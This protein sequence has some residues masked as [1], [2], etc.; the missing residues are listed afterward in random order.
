MAISMDRADS[1]ARYEKE[2]L[3]NDCIE[4]AMLCERYSDELYIASWDDAIFWM[5]K[6]IEIREN[7]YG[8]NSIKNIAQY[9]R[10]AWIYADKPSL[11]T[12]LKWYK[13]ALKIREK[14]LGKNDS[15]LVL[16]Y[17]AIAGIYLN[18]GEYEQ[19][20]EYITHAKEIE[21]KNRPNDNPVSYR[22]YE[23]LAY[24]YGM[25]YF[26]GYQSGMPAPVQPEADILMEKEILKKMVDSAVKE[27]GEES[28]EAVACIEKYIHDIKMPAQERL[29]LASKILK[30]YY[31]QYD[32]FEKRKKDNE[33]INYT[34]QRI[35]ADI[36]FSWMR[37]G[38]FSWDKDSQFDKDRSGIGWAIK[39]IQ[40]NVSSEISEWLIARFNAHDQKMI[41]DIIALEGMKLPIR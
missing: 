5:K 30:I 39:W 19:S 22:V 24:Y 21:E 31:E 18:K 33:I 4:N 8:K 37:G 14:V 11:T 15:S 36:W 35:P 40:Q 20:M 34:C 17:L 23:K 26:E 28:C 3:S 29:T 41:R 7:L 13:K 27:Y 10:L 38:W 1:L 2:K 12:A 6:A 32:E 9:E 16:D 25:R